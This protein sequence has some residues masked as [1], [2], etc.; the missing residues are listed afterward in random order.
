MNNFNNEIIMIDE[1]LKKDFKLLKVK[2]QRTKNNLCKKDITECLTTSIKED[3]IK[4]IGGGTY[5]SI[6]KSEDLKGRSI[7]IKMIINVDITG[8]KKQKLNCKMNKELE[9]TIAMGELGVGP[10]IYDAIFHEINSDEIDKY[11]NL[12]KMLDLIKN[13]HKN[14]NDNGSGNKTHA[15][16][17]L[18]ESNIDTCNKR[19]GKKV[20]NCHLMNIQ[21][22]SM[23]GFEKDGNDALFKSNLDNNV[24]YEIIT[25]FIDLIYKQIFELYVYC[26]DIKPANFVINTSLV[27]DVKMIDFG[28]DF[29][30]STNIYNEY[31]NE[32]VMYE[33]LYPK[34][35]L[36]FS[37]VIQILLILDHQNF[38]Y[39]MSQETISRYSMCFFKNK[40]MSK[41]INLDWKKLIKQIVF[42]AYNNNEEKIFDP[43][44]ML[45]HYSGIGDYYEKSEDKVYETIIGILEK[46]IY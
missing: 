24:K 18:L 33:N 43:S 17:K 21:I 4:Y 38:F 2:E 19:K 41:I 34:E 16:F 13:G 32:E 40:L 36:F 29:C 31:D 6:F 30:V 22:I 14:K 37:N 23:Q 45:I 5:G 1:S 25:R 3:T 20:K 15:Q 35:I 26:Y 10:I 44:N 12:S 8:S 39:E 42:S 11:K 46:Y 28:I 7:I 27:L 9:L